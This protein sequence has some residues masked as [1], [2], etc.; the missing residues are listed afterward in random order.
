MFNDLLFHGAV[1]VA[2]SNGA[3][4]VPITDPL[5]QVAEEV[6]PQA[7]GAK[8]PILSMQNAKKC[9]SIIFDASIRFNSEFGQFNSEGMNTPDVH[10]H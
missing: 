4:K 1:T 8:S 6:R 5:S 9:N 3:V 7:F 10:A 2:C